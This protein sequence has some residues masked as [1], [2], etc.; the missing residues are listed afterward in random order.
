MSFFRGSL[1]TMAD[2]SKKPIEDLVIGDVVFDGYEKNVLIRG[3]LNLYNTV[4]W[5]TDDN[6]PGQKPIKINNEIVCMKDQIFMGADNNF[7][8]LNGLENELLYPK[9]IKNFYFIAHRNVIIS[10]PNFNISSKIKKLE[11]GSIIMKDTGPVEVNSIEFLEPLVMKPN[12]K[13]VWKDFYF[14]NNHVIEEISVEDFEP[15]SDDIIKHKVGGRGTYIVDGYIC[16]STQN[17]FWDY[18]KNVM[19]PEGKY[20]VQE[21]NGV[22]ERVIYK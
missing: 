3:L 21:L 5:R 11:I 15:D 22:I 2:G 17:K 19:I 10:A 7:Y 4:P 9:N 13:C 18:D 20:H 1:V 8:I 14:N 12:T 16:L 6:I